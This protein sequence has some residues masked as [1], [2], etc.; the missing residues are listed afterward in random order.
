MS[1]PNP[2]AWCVVSVDPG[3][4][5][6][7]AAALIDTSQSTV[8]SAMKRAHRKGLLKTFTIT[9]S[10][11]DQAIS[12]LKFT[13]EYWYRNHIEL[14]RVAA[15][16]CTLA[17]EDFQL[18]TM[19]ADITSLRI[20]SG[21]DCMLK[22]G[23]IEESSEQHAVYVKQMPGDMGFCTD[24]MLKDWSLWRGRTVH[25]RDALKHLASRVNKL[26]G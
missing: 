6:G 12:I 8:A 15:R 22:A 17:I 19:S 21:L 25:E 1:G 10:H 16:R 23:G 7:V 3:G 20:I 13:N 14:A 5:T 4:T 24:S 26:L 18:R 11:S 2:N 9:G